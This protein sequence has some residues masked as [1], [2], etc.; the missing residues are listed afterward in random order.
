MCGAVIERSKKDL[1]F[2]IAWHI[3][4]H[5]KDCK[6]REKTSQDSFH[7]QVTRICFDD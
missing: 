5:E 6:K 3:N 7:K 1:S 4:K 2:F